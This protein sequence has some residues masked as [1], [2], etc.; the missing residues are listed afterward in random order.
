M[1]TS[2]KLNIIFR[3]IAILFSFCCLIIQT[4]KIN[5]FSGAWYFT[6]STIVYSIGIILG[7]VFLIMYLFLFRKY[8]IKY[9]ISYLIMIIILL[10]FLIYGSLNY[11]RDLY[12]GKIE[13]K[14]EIYKI[15]N[16]SYYEDYPDRPKRIELSYPGCSTLTINDETYFDLIKNNPCDQTRIVYDA[17]YDETT[18]PHIHHIIIKFYENTGILDSVQIV[19]DEN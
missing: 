10:P 3:F 14:T 6:A 15:P 16:E 12:I 11:Y 7:V 17:V 19:Y 8:K 5:N 2:N 4:F 13:L 18:Y 1:K 9:G